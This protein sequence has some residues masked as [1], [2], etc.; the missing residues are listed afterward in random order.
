MTSDRGWGCMLRCGQM[1]VAQALVNQHLGKIFNIYQ[2]SLLF[3]K[4]KCW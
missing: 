3:N 4:F 2:L 1:V